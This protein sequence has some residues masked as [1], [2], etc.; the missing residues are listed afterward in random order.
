MGVSGN[1][2][3]EQVLLWT[4]WVILV[5]TGIIAF[6]LLVGGDVLGKTGGVALLWVVDSLL[7]TLKR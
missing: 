2:L 3:S 1:G 4:G 7:K 6:M 5:V